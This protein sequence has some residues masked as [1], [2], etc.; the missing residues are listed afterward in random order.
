MR[1]H[2]AVFLAAWLHA[3]L[4]SGAAALIVVPPG[5]EM[6]DGDSFTG[7]PFSTF[8]GFCNFGE[9]F[10]QIYSGDYIGSVS[11]D[12]MWFRQDA[13]EG[14][15]PT[16]FTI[17]NVMVTLAHTMAPAGTAG[18]LFVENYEGGGTVVFAGDLA[19][20]S[21]GLAVGQK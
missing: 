13:V 3:G 17:P 4:A 7:V 15:G 16:N 10:Q 6:I 5:L 19:V 14:L 8:P 11:I 18:G 21:D 20:D 1:S 2:F 9:R 12:G